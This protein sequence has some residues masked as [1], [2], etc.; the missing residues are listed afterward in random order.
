MTGDFN[1]SDSSSV[2]Q[3]ITGQTTLFN[4]EVTSFWDD[5]AEVYAE[6]TSTKPEYTLNLRT[7]PRWQ[8]K[9]VAVTSGRLDRIYLRD[10][11]PKPFPELKF[12]SL[13]V[14]EIDEKAR[15]CAS[16]HYGVVAEI[17]IA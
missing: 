2:N 17:E 14:K 6:M 8:G 15:Y 16:D 13:F 3:Y 1:C 5:L 10:A 4:T 12:F 7:N 11:F 9:D